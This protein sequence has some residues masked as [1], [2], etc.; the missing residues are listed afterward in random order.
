MKKKI[1]NQKIFNRI[2]SFVLCLLIVFSAIPS[3]IFAEAANAVNILGDTD[4]SSRSGSDIYSYAGDAFE[5][6]A[7][8]EESVKHFHLED[9]TYVSAQ[10][11]YPVHYVDEE[12]VMQDIDNQLTEA[13]GGVFTNKN[14]RIKFAKKINGNETLFTLHDGN[15]K[16]ALSLNN[17]IK[18]VNGLVINNNDSEEPTQLQKMM[19]LEKLSSS[20]I[21]KDILSGVDL[22]YVAQSNNIKENI[23]VKEKSDAYTYCFEL[24]LNGLSA[25]LLES[26]DIRVV[27]EKT[28]EVQYVIPAPVVFDSKNEHAPNGL[29]YYT[30]ENING[31]KYVLSVTVSAEWMNDENRSFPVT[32]DP[33]IVASNSYVLDTSVSSAAP[34]SS[35]GSDTAL[36]INTYRLAHWKT[37]SLPYIPSSAYITNATITMRSSLTDGDYVAAYEVLTDWNESLTWNQYTNST[38]PKGKVGDTVID[39]KIFLSIEGRGKCRCHRRTGTIGHSR[40]TQTRN[41]KR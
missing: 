11:N 5:V 27:N 10:Y 31:G 33:A 40:Q 20:I 2:L 13:A 17:A 18:G 37:T 6:E 15:T 8:R 4:S 25:E 30:L 39:C 19:N 29:S 35:F 32:I 7:L 22:E 3:V 14:A 26:G 41:A 38:S 12:G 9:G 16:L 28:K 34:D 23:I 36:Y 1:L 24:K 21:Y